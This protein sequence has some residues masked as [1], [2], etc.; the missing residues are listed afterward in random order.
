MRLSMREC[1]EIEGAASKPRSPQLRVLVVQLVSM[2]RSLRQ[3]FFFYE[4]SGVRMF[5]NRL[6]NESA[7]SRAE[8]LMRNR[9]SKTLWLGLSYGNGGQEELSAWTGERDGQQGN[10]LTPQGPHMSYD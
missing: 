6:F 5:Y 10:G 2:P 3:I 4:E 1:Q 7:L 8:C 9:S